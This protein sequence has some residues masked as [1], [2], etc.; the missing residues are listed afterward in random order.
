MKERGIKFGRGAKPLLDAPKQYILDNSFVL[1][2]LT[3]YI[4]NDILAICH[5]K[6]RKRSQHSIAPDVVTNGYHAI[7]KKSQRFARIQ[8]ATAHTGKNPEYGKNAVNTIY[9]NDDK[10]YDNYQALL[11]ITY[12]TRYQLMLETQN[13]NVLE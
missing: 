13:A 4:Y 6:K 7:L 1:T 10:I 2:Y 8:S 12:L 3:T 9:H 11:L 5:T